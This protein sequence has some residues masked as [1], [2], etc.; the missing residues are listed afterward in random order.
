MLPVL[1]AGTW[2]WD[3]AT[4]DIDWEASTAAPAALVGVFASEPRH[5]DLVWAQSQDDL[6]LRNA[7]FREAV[8][9]LAA[10]IHGIPKDELESED[11][12][13]HRRALRVR[14]GAVAALLLLVVGL[15]V[16]GVLALRAAE[17]ARERCATW[18]TPTATSTT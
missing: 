8:A 14:R 6:D 15:G 11:V 2:V 5:L 13:Q 10:P 3:N 17:T 4:S 9:D 1:T 18:R 7:R 16:A 12:R